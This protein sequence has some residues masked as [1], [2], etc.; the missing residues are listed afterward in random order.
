MANFPDLD[1]PA[2]E[3]HDGVRE[4]PLEPLPTE[5]TKLAADRESE[6]QR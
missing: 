1:N 4:M 6:A 3:A 2:R 5:S